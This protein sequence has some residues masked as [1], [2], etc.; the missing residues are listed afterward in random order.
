M[1]IALNAQLFRQNEK[2]AGKTCVLK[3]THSNYIKMFEL[4]IDLWDLFAAVEYI[5]EFVDKFKNE[6]NLR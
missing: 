5:I 3:Y 1:Q 6:L 4:D 2:C